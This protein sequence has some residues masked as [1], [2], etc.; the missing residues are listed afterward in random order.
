MLTL[1]LPPNISEICLWAQRDPPESKAAELFA[2]VKD[3]FISQG[4]G[5]RVVLPP[6]QFK[7]VNDW[8]KGA[9]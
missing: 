5:V 7:D 2:K 1:E 8:L 3:R 4:R 9:A 6:P